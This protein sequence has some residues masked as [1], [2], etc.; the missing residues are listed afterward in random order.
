MGVVPGCMSVDSHL[1]GMCRG[2]KRELDLLE[3]ELQTVMR[4]LVGA[5]NQAQSSGNIAN[6]HNL[7][8]YFQ[9]CNKYFLKSKQPS[10]TWHGGTR[11]GLGG[12]RQVGLCEFKTSLVYMSCSRPPKNT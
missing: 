2:Q 1:A 5:G 9:P 3:L 6:V 8:D 12:L 4:C 7:R 11:P 10:L